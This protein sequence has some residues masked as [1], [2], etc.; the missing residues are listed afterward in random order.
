MILRSTQYIIY[1]LTFSSFFLRAQHSEKTEDELFRL[2]NLAYDNLVINPD[3]ALAYASE[4]LNLSKAINDSLEIASALDLIGSGYYY[5]NKLEKALEYHISAHGIFERSKDYS[6]LSTTHL[7]I[8]NVYNDLG[9]YLRAIDHYLKSME[10]DKRIDYPEGEAITAVNI[11]NIFLAQENYKLAEKYIDQSIAIATKY[12]LESTIANGYNLKSELLLHRGEIQKAEELAYKALRIAKEYHDQFE[13]ASSYCSLGLVASERN[14]HSAAIEQCGKAVK[15]MV[16]YGDPYS[17]SLYRSFLAKV[18][19]KAGRFSEG[20]KEA[21]EAYAISKKEKNSRYLIR[22][23][24]LIL[25]QA[26]EGSE[27]PWKA[28]EL[29]KEYKLYNDTL[30]K[31]NI[32]EKLLQQQNALKEHENEVLSSRNKLQNEIISR[33]KLVLI[34]VTILLIVCVTFILS[35]V[36][37]IRKRKQYNRIL[38]EKTDLIQKK[39]TEIDHQSNLLIRKNLELENLNQTKDKLFSILTHDLKQPFNQILGILELLEYN[40]ISEEDKK[41]LLEGLKESVSHTRSSV[42]NLLIWSK[43]QFTGMNVR[44]GSVKLMAIIETLQKQLS[45]ALK[46][47]ELQLKIKVSNDLKVY[48]DPDHTEIILRNLI[49]NAIKFSPTGGVIEISADQDSKDF[50]KLEVR[51]YGIGMSQKQIDSMLDFNEN[52]STPGTLNEKGTGLGILIVHEFLEVN[53]GELKIESIKG[54]GSSFVVILPTAAI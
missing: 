20:L 3:T 52:L 33:N 31:L 49:V 37:S 47:K 4:Y 51:D 16:D 29:Y 8:G 27:N 54:E 5:Q 1:I 30:I 48:A 41:E 17:I 40:Q 2:Y 19:L 7:S 53:K 9:F 43:N 36:I 10:Y 32:Q 45:S 39:Q 34:I 15:L 46:N 35:L 18:Y 6:G 26:Y 28:L 23:S 24:S 22:E 12:K 11:A 44:P 42:E 21:Q 14:D 38:V 50:V 13:I 25:S